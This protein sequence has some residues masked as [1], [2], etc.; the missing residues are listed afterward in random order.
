MRDS[1]EY[2]YEELGKKYNIPAKCIEQLEK[3]WWYAVRKEMAS[4]SGRKILF[5]NFGSIY[6][7]MYTLH[8][9]NEWNKKAIV[10][11]EEKWKSGRIPWMNYLRK[12]I[13][14][15]RTHTQ[16]QEMLDNIRKRANRKKGERG[17]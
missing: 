2:I 6:V 15:T 13:L 11:L 7:D 9:K 5:P 16:C 17:L 14:Y 3:D 10:D 8:G 12:W 1:I 4:K